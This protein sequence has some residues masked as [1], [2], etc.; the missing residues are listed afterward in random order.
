MSRFLVVLLLASGCAQ[1]IPPPEVWRAAIASP[2][3]SLHLVD[4]E[5]WRVFEVRQPAFGRKRLELRE[6]FGGSPEPIRVA[7]KGVAWRWFDPVN[8]LVDPKFYERNGHS[9]NYR[10]QHPW[11]GQEWVLAARARSHSVRGISLPMLDEAAPR[12]LFFEGHDRPR[13]GQQPIGQLVLDAASRRL[14]FGQLEGREVEIEQVGTFAWDREPG[15]LQHLVTPFP[16]SGEFVVRIDG[17]E[18]ARF[19]KRPKQGTFTTFRLAI[20]RDQGEAER[21][22]SLWLFLAFHR[23]H[24][25]VVEMERP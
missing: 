20:R 2:E 3:Q 16:G 6:E 8:L 12:L 1:V 9:A 24:E 19:L 21:D 14:L 23:M 15:L 7:W 25:F 22:L 11:S 13:E 17:R 18:T 10:F 4:G 5:D